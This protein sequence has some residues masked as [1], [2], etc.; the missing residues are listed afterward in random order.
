M[1]RCNTAFCRL[2]RRCRRTGA[3]L[4]ALPLAPVAERQYRYPD[5]PMERAVVV[6]GTSA[7]RIEVRPLMR[8]HAGATDYWDGNWIDCLIT[9]A[10]GGFRAEYTACLRA[11]ELAGFRRDLERLYEE[12][13]GRGGFKSIEE[14]LTIEVIGDGRGHFRGPCRLR[15][16][17]GDG[18]TL[19]FDIEFDETDIPA[20]I[21][22]MRRIESDFPVVGSPAA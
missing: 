4:A 9:A 3:P 22:Q 18:N 5:E 19:L 15:D 6:V 11:E 21:G 10:A 20:M 8:S 7:A 2:T 1:A 17:A 12:L 13:E 14:W 16:R